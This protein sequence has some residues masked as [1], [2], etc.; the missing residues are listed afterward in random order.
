MNLEIVY[1]FLKEIQNT[2]KEYINQNSDKKGTIGITLADDQFSYS[3]GKYKECSMK[4]EE[5]D[6]I[7]HF[8]SQY[9]GFSK[10]VFNGRFYGLNLKNVNMLLNSNLCSDF[11]SF[12][13]T[14]QKSEEMIGHQMLGMI[15]DLAAT[16]NK[17]S[18]PL[19]FSIEDNV[20]WCLGDGISLD[21]S[22]YHNRLIIDMLKKYGT[23]KVE[24]STTTITVTDTLLFWK[25]T[26]KDG[27]YSVGSLLN[28]ISQ[29]LGKSEYL[30]AGIIIR[31]FSI[32]VNGKVYYFE[33]GLSER[34]KAELV[35]AL[36]KKCK[37]EV[38]M[39]SK[40]Y[41]IRLTEYSN[42]INPDEKGRKI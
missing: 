29:C 38:D 4:Q 7:A 18:S 6:M 35:D 13:N 1:N 11:E 14:V 2:I 12:T 10:D 3:F 27:E 28:T 15:R 41:I 17:N 19:I 40:D 21:N 8:L 25:D 36:S 22:R 37:M 9:F 23:E 5:V 26:C 34:T 42:L 20:L 32:S 33:K 30:M 16:N 31:D 39:V 24:G